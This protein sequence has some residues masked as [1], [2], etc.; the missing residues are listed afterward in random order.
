MGVSNEAPFIK[1]AKKVSALGGHIKNESKPK[2][3]SIGSSKNTRPYSKVQCR[4]F[5]AYR[6]Q[7]H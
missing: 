1:M 4:E 2:K 5:K 7:G 6:G 3:T